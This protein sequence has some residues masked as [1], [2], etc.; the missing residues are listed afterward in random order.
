MERELE[1]RSEVGDVQS[2]QSTVPYMCPAL[3][4]LLFLSLIYLVLF[5][6]F[7]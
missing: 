4:F 3:M 1:K 5:G 6:C 2:T 7:H